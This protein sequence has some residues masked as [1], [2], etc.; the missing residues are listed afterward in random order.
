M[1]F[2]VAPAI[3]ACTWCLKSL[4]SVGIVVCF[5][6]IL[7]AAFRLARFNVNTV[8]VP[9]HS[10]PPRPDFHDGRILYRC[11]YLDN[12]CWAWGLVSVNAVTMAVIVSLLGLLMV[13]SIPFRNFR[14]L[15]QNKR[16]R[17][18][19]ALIMAT[20]LTGGV[21]VGASVFFGGA[22]VL[23]I[24]CGAADGLITT[25]HFKRTGNP[26]FEDLLVSE[27]EDS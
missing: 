9:G 3:L 13:S 15:R 8:I 21:I 18:L 6:Y 10:R 4:G 26:F 5:W 22:A 27:S 20:A 16:S 11:I 14:D 17:A 12:E 2:G 1:G 19:F 25:V 7:C 24:T 23:Y